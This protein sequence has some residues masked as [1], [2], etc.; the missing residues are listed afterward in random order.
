MDLFYPEGQSVNDSIDPECCSMSYITVDQIAR[1]ALKLGR[2]T[3]IDRH[4]ISLPVLANPSAPPIRP[5]MA[6]VGMG[7][8]HLRGRDAAFWFE[9]S[10][11]NLQLCGRCTGVVC[12]SGRSGIHF[13][14]SG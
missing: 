3:M 12:V 14:L 10:S 2:G 13:P 1:A 5:D 9:L 4:Q 8:S 7:G 11:K 6:G